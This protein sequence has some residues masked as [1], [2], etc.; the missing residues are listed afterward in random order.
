MCPRQEEKGGQTG[1]D[2]PHTGFTCRT[3][4]FGGDYESC[5]QHDNVA[6]SI[7]EFVKVGA[8]GRAQQDSQREHIGA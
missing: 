5:K 3:I 1:H 8:E 7:E 6:E 2:V 4:Q